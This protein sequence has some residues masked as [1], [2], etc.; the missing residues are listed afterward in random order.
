MAAALMGSLAWAGHAVAS[1]PA[2]V[3]VDA[4]HLC[5]AAL[6]LGMLPP[7]ALV[8]HRA[9]ASRDVG[10]LRLAGRA[11]Q[12]FSPPAVAAVLVLAVSGSLN[13][14][15]LVGSPDKLLGSAYGL[16]LSAKLA[17][18]ALMLALAASNRLQLTPRIAGAAR[19]D[20]AALLAARRLRRNVLA[21]MLLAAA[22]IGVVGTLGV[23][24]PAVHEQPA[25]H[26]HEHDHEHDM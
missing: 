5:A 10:W 4:A 16:L 17:L 26:H 3:W 1:H 9:A 2:H 13:S 6:W 14:W 19:P 7:L 8:V 15:W 22:L 20:T 25:H 21:E 24:P 18:F 23:T 11:A 12:V